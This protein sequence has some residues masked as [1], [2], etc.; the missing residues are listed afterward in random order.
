MSKMRSCHGKESETS[1]SV[2]YWNPRP[3]AATIAVLHLGAITFAVI[4]KE[5]S[6][7]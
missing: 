4:I 2:T 5:N 3:W 1:R 7:W 6:S